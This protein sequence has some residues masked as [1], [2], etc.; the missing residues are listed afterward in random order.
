MIAKNNMFRF[1][2]LCLLFPVMS[3]AQS[4]FQ[5]GYII[6][7]AKDTLNGLIK[8]K[9]YHNNSNHCDFQKAGSDSVKRFYPG[10]IKGYRFDNGKYYVS[11]EIGGSKVFMEYLI[12]GKLDVYFYQDERGDNHYYAAK[13]TLKPQELKYSKENRYSNGKS[14]VYESKLYIGILNYLTQD[15]GEMTEKLK[16]M[17]EPDHKNLIDIAKVYHNYKCKDE[18]C[19]IYEKKIPRKIKVAL[20][21]GSNLFFNTISNLDRKIYPSY[22]YQFLFQQAQRRERLYIGIGLFNEGIIYDNEESK[23]YNQNHIR[24][25]RIPFSLNYIS[26]RKGFSPYIAYEFDLRYL[27]YFQALKV[28]VKYQVKKFSFLLIPDIKTSMFIMPIAAGLNF[29]LMYDIR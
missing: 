7:L 10:D 20:Y 12:H 29:G 25:I 4:E 28:G 24:Y 22:G 5:Q 15:C 6:T 9:S 26:Q 14:Y 21:G 27:G 19:I 18:K 13:D 17:K 16:S 23:A 11:R 3:S 2:L 8:N 1:T